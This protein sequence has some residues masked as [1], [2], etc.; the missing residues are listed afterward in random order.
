MLSDAEPQLKVL[1]EKAR[2]FLAL[3]HRNQALV[4][5]AGID[6]ELLSIYEM[7]KHLCKYEEG[8]IEEAEGIATHAAKC[9]TLLLSKNL[10]KTKEDLTGVSAQITEKTTALSNRLLEFVLDNLISQLRKDGV[11][12]QKTFQSQSIRGEIQQGKIEEFTQ[13]SAKFEGFKLGSK[14]DKTSPFTALQAQGVANINSE[15]TN[16]LIALYK[17]VQALQLCFNS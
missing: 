3:A 8:V 12:T 1:F 2:A 17:A 14:M 6:H 5:A 10:V 9:F 13:A 7:I 4:L 11:I 15:T 16:N